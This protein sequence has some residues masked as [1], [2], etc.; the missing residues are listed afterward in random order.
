MNGGTP[1]AIE[2]RF[3]H[4]PV[5]V[6]E[7]V[8][9][10]STVPSGAFLD[11]TV[12]GGGHARALLNARPDLSLIGLDRDPSAVEAATTLLAGRGAKI[13]HASFGQLGD[14]LDSLGVSRIVGS[15]FDFGVSSPQLD[16]A[17]RGFS[18]RQDGPLDMR[19]DCA[20]ELSADQVVNTWSTDE[21]AGILRSY[22]DERYANRIAAAISSARPIASTSALAEVVRDAIPAPARRRGGHPAKR[23]FQAIRIAVNDEL[24]QIEPAL[25]TAIDRMAP[26]GRGVILSY[27]SGEDRIVKQVLHRRA[28]LADE[29]RFRGLPRAADQAPPAIEL[30]PRGSRRPSTAEIADNP[31]ASSARFRAFCKLGSDQGEGAC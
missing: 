18:Y 1:T 9:H 23:T 30:V 14:V 31:R 19:M 10:L 21:L 4:H 7:V 8:E 29:S 6:T 17:E 12:G 20:Q 26:E 28:G 25:E 11:A 5:M 3:V 27:H 13:R 24:N 2:R 15:L 16:M 22:G